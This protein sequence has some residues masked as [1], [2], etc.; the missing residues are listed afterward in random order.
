MSRR[1]PSQPW[2]NVREP[3]DFAVSYLL[4]DAVAYLLSLGIDPGLVRLN[5][6]DTFNELQGAR[7]VDPDRHRFLNTPLETAVF[8]K[9]DC[10]LTSWRYQAVL[11]EIAVLLLR[12]SGEAASALA[13]DALAFNDD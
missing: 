13:R 1:V 7:D 10:F 2:Q 3:L 12:F 4:V 6:A 9:S 11:K 8:R 5:E